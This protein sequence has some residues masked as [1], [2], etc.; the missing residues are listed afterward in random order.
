MLY[1]CRILTSLAAILATPVALRRQGPT[2]LLSPV[3]ATLPR[4]PVPSVTC[5]QCLTATP[6]PQQHRR[7]RPSTQRG[8]SCGDTAPGTGQQRRPCAT[9]G[10]GRSSDILE[11]PSLPGIERAATTS[12]SP[13]AGSAPSVAERSL[14]E[15]RAPWLPS[16][17]RTPS[18]RGLLRSARC[19]GPAPRPL[20][21]AHRPSAE[22][23]APLAAAALLPLPG[24]YEETPLRDGGC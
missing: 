1:F 9:A 22:H 5:A 17:P 16:P 19:P 7:S 8:H 10:P 12:P 11:A 14:P 18:E 6:G 15:T 23:R 13:A 20:Q 2:A 21:S 24:A 4:P 3:K